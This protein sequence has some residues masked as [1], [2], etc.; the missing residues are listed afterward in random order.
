MLRSEE[1]SAVLPGRSIIAGRQ[2]LSNQLTGGQPGV[3]LG[4]TVWGE[5]YR[6]RGLIFRWLVIFLAV[7]VA[8]WLFPDRIVYPDWQAAA[9]FAAVL[10]LLNAFL[11]PVLTFLTLPLSCLTFGLFAI[12]VNGFVFWLAAQLYQGVRVA[13]FLDAII[14]AL[15]VSVVSFV[16][17]R[18]PK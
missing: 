7:L 15:V 16:L 8:A 13:S 9:V 14:G 12:I 2:T 5:D 17:S 6:L 1:P 3:I 18:G 10:G 4:R 11:R